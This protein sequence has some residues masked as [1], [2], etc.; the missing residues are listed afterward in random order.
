MALLPNLPSNANIK[1][2]IQNRFGGLEHLRQSS[3][4]TLWDMQ[5]MCSY[6]APALAT[7]PP[8]WNY[9]T[10]TKPNGMY[11]TADH[12]FIVDGTNLYVDGVVVRQVQDN[13]KTFCG[14]GHRVVILPDKIMYNSDGTFT[15]LE[16]TFSASGLVIGN[17]T[18]AGV[19]AK[20]NAIT[21]A[22]PFP[23]NVGDAV[24]ISGCSEDYNN[25]T[26]VI[27]EKSA[28]S[29]QIRFY[30]NTFRLPSNA[31]EGATDYTEAGTVTISRGMPDMDYICENDNRLWGCK[32]D[33]IYACKLGDPSNWN[34]FDGLATDSY[35]VDSGSP[36]DFTACISFLGYPVFFKEDKIYKIYGSKPSNYEIMASAVSGV[37][38]GSSKSLAIAG[39][40]LHYLS[41]TGV[42]SYTGGMPYV[43]SDP[44][45]DELLSEAVAGSDGT[46]LWINMRHGEDGTYTTYVYDTTNKLWHKEDDVR[47]IDFAYKKGLYC[48]DENGRIYL[49]GRPEEKPETVTKETTFNSMVEFND[50]DWQVIDSKYPIRSVLRFETFPGAELKIFIQYNSDGEWKQVAAVNG[51][52]TKRQWFMPI[53]IKRCEHYRF[54]IE[55]K[56]QWKIYALEQEFYTGAYTRR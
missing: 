51:Q 34:S 4:G 48:E 31:P 9:M 32:G 42:V 12:L 56:G 50:F 25:L 8:R 45:G 53:S 30:E 3:N 29:L 49:T 10:V 35:V 15:E 1:R 54:K 23:F 19:A 5:N 22:T 43:I 14:I 24:T 52:K 6:Y 36:G 16:S 33:T 47:V 41:R 38:A 55:G 40:T 17:G 44:L 7:R 37:Q 46:K 20:M 28:D 39:E 26:V 11:S 21:S 27:R 13:K 18:Y 2:Q